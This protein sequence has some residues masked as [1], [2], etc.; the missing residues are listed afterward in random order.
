MASKSILPPETEADDGYEAEFD[1]FIERNRDALNESL[2]IAYEEME[3]GVYS[4]KT[5][6][7]IISEGKARFPRC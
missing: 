1:A 4:T 6:K 7:D 3:N 5:I 2:R